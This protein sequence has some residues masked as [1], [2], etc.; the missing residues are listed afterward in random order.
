[1]HLPVPRLHALVV[2]WWLS[3]A[4]LARLVLAKL[5][6]EPDKHLLDLVPAA[7]LVGVVQGHSVLPLLP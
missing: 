3:Q 2:A 1:M 7:A 4:V 5:V 6:G